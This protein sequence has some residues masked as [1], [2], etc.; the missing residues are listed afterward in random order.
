MTAPC[1]SRLEL[2]MAI[3]FVGIVP[4]CGSSSSPDDDDIDVDVSPDAG[5][6]DAA[7]RTDTAT[8]PSMP[9]VPAPVGK[10]LF[11]EV[12]YHPV[13]ENAAVDNHEFLELHNRGDAPVTLTGWKLEGDVRFAFPAGTSI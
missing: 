11:S 1:P 4:A 12:M 2:L 5:Q 13:L 7:A 9:V 3:L 8:E 10:V 6:R